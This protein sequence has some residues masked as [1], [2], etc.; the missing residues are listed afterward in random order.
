[1]K[2]DKQTYIKFCMKFNTEKD[3]VVIR[4]LQSKEN[5][6]QYIRNLVWSD[7]T[8]QEQCKSSN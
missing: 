3:A 7:L 2:K 1:M 8:L 4:T 5:K 6:T